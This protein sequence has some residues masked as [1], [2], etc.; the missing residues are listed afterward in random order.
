MEKNKFDPSLNV[1]YRRHQQLDFLFFPKNVAV[2]GATEKLNSVGRTLLWNLLRSPFGGTIYPVNPKRKSVLGITAFSSITKVPVPVDLAIIVV[3]AAYVPSVIEECVQAKVSTAIIISAGFTEMG[4]SGKKLEK[5]ILEQAKKGKMRIIGPNCLGIMNPITGLNATFAA[6]MALKGNVAFI[7]QSGALC[8]AVLDWSLKEK[9]G[10]SSFVSIGSMVDV[11]WGDLI[12]YFGNDPH[13]QSILIYMES[14][15]DCRSFLSAARE[16]ALTKPIILIKAGVTEQSAKAAASHTGALSGSD[17]V[18]NAALRRVGVLRVDSISELFSMAEILSKHPKPKGPYLTIITNAGGPGVIATDALI[19]N[20]AALTELNETVIEQ[21]NEFLPEAWSH[22]NPIDILGDATADLY[23]RSLKI[24]A[25]DEKAC[26]ILAILTPQ[27]MTDPTAI[28]EELKK[29]AKIKDKPVLASWM[30][31]C[32]V[33][34]G[35]EILTENQIPCFAFPDEACKT[36][37]YMW[38]YSYNLKGL[39]ETPKLQQ[40]FSEENQRVEKV[41]LLLDKVKGEKRSLLTEA[42]SKEVLTAFDIPTVMTYKA[43]VVEEAVEFAEKATFPVVLK[44]LS[45]TITHKTDVGGVK[46]NIKNKEE[47]RKAFLEIQE[48]V[49]QA[50]GEGHFDGVT[51]QPMINLTQGYEIILGSSIDPQF[52]PVLLFG[53][54][55]QLVEVFQDRALALPPLTSTLARRMM[56]ETKI[57]K[58][59]KGVRGRSAVDLANLEAI[60]VRFSDLIA[61]FPSIVECD[62]NPLFVSPDKIVALDARIVLQDPEISQEKLPQLAI[63]PYPLHYIEKIFLQDQRPVVMRPIRPE[64][65]PLMTKF[66]RDISERSLFERYLKVLHYDELIQKERLITI[67]FNDYDREIAIVLELQE[68]NKEPEIIGIGRLSKLAGTEEATFALLIKDSYQHQKLG[69]KLLY[70]LLKIAKD[71]KIKKVIAQMRPENEEMQA[72][73]KKLGFTLQKEEKSALI[74]AELDV[75][76]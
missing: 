68:E 18:L 59:L 21:L 29:Y 52:G 27:Y 6:D 38:Q 33:E 54:G 13:T 65:E 22:N 56:E 71:E 7:S 46:L 76:E 70:K 2:I 25:E 74:I 58:A 60:L 40:T 24:A 28:A 30:G 20:K 53:L 14:V 63:R 5:Q 61:A 16:V 55:G 75:G 23:A 10:F 1:L 8:T 51:V 67:C 43:R 73:C 47:V 44:L 69:S 39:Y 41:R 3:P 35:I 49:R 57:Y 9:V 31:A 15:G 62:I 50:K 36:F 32:S 4:E 17:D 19:K 37:A 42:E 12:N 66:F 45:K 72:I 34:K 48:S 11:N 26:G 64:D